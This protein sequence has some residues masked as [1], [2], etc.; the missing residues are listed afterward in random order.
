MDCRD[1]RELAD[2][3]LGDELLTETNHELLR[4]LEQ[5]PSCRADLAARRAVRDGVRRAFARAADLEPSPEFLTSLRARLRSTAL[6]TPV[7]RRMGVR[8]WWALA[9]VLALAV[10]AGLAYRGRGGELAELSRA[11]VGDHRNCALQFRLAEK[12]IALDEAARRY[13]VV[14]RALETLPPD[15][16]R[17]AVGPAHVL[18]RHACIFMGRRFAHIVLEFRGARVSMLVADGGR[19]D[20]APSNTSDATIETP[21]SVDGLSLVSFRA[22]RRLV[23]LTGDVAASDLSALA[24]VVAPPIRRSLSG[25]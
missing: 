25:L 3:F 21:R 12:P 18:E 2:S 4:H 9:A 14:Y 24:D 10:A 15:D 1:V 22:S 17:T 11:A 13:G 8:A 6:E 16:I 5:C 19:A 7:R 20:A 23:F